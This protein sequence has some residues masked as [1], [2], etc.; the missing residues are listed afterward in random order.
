MN[1]LKEVPFHTFLV[2]IYIVLFVFA[3]NAE[4]LSFDMTFRTIII[5]M[6]FSTLVYFLSKLILRDKIKAGIFSTILLFGLFSYGLLY[7]NCENLYFDDKW[8]FANI[9]RYLV[10]IYILVYLPVLY[11]FYRTKRILTYIN[12]FFN[13]LLFIIILMNIFGIL[14]FE[15]SSERL[16]RKTNQNPI[17]QSMQVM[18]VLREGAARENLPDIYYLILD[19]YA[20]DKILSKFYGLDN[21]PFTEF[22]RKKG[23]YIAGQSRC[24]YPITRLSLS[25]SLNISYLDSLTD[26]A[27]K[28]ATQSMIYQNFV[29]YY[30]K[31]SGYKIIHMPSGYAVT[32]RNEYADVEYSLFGPNEFER[33]IM[34]LTIFRLDDLS[35]IITYFRLSRQFALLK[36]IPKESTPKFCFIHLVCPHPPF[37]FNKVGKLTLHAI[38]D[39]GWETRDDYLK[40]LEYV[41]SVI[42][43]FITELI[44]KDKTKKPIIIIQSDHG[45]WMRDSDADN[46]YAART[47]ILNAF[48]VPENIQ[49][50][51]YENIS[52]VNSFRVVFNEMFHAGLPLLPDKSPDS[53]LFFNDPVF[54][55]YYTISSPS[56]KIKIKINEPD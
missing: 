3:H 33:S 10:F 43:K 19:G 26:K 48:Y 1:R 41:N 14:F 44:Q 8:P 6:L 38:S 30:L 21:N 15:I 17:L 12:Y 27:H 49:S 24:N 22:L 51:L 25:S 13:V 55:N 46:I 37:V 42:T 9:H 35:G 45:P 2:C 47:A 28:G 23:F 54:K 4:K 34:R 20:N 18:P 16:Y 5:G 56:R 40:Q 53:T 52:P 32:N 7:N 50:K 31:G 39:M 29:T 36:E 11:L